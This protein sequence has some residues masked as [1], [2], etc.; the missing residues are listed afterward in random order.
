MDITRQLHNDHTEL[1]SLAADVMRATG[2]RGPGSRSN[3]FAQFDRELRR[4][5]GAVEDALVRPLIRRDSMAP[6]IANI[7]TQ[8]STMRRELKTLGHGPTD[9]EGWTKQFEQLKAQLDDICGRHEAIAHR[10]ESEIGEGAN[11]G[12]AFTQ[13][14]LK[15]MHAWN[16][17]RI[18]IGA[19]AG[20][21]VAAAVVAGLRGRHNG[22]GEAHVGDDFE[23]RLETDETVRLI[24]SNKV[25]GT[26]VVDSEGQPIG[27][28][29]NF[30]VDKYTGRVAYA[31][32]SFGGVMGFANSYFPIPWPMLDYD[33]AA[34]AYA[35]SVT[36]EDLAR[37]PRFEKD[38][39]PEFDAGY[40]SR[41]IRFYRGEGEGPEGL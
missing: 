7:K 18:G 15:R 2:G 11:L 38:T 41:V 19:V 32:L 16:W 17:N 13:A 35:L 5:L 27:R 24:A 36:R 34:D 25:E 4:H 37:A 1:K 9:R 22:E 14:K 8:H 12:E 39:S 23:H 26:K 20:A 21:A 29:E 31:V 3:Q 30:M 28:I 10:A 33:T 40:R 6:A